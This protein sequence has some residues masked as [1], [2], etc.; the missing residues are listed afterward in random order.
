MCLGEARGCKAVNTSALHLR[1]RSSCSRHSLICS[2]HSLLMIETV[3]LGHVSYRDVALPL[4]EVI[5]PNFAIL[6][7]PVYLGFM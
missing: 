1:N 3:R 5:H 7:L 4:V 2:R 6:C